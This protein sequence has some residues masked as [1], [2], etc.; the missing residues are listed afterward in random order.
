MIGG[1]LAEAS[2]ADQIKGC[3]VFTV[4]AL[5]TKP[6]GK[7]VSDL[8]GLKIFRKIADQLRADG[9]DITKPGPGSAC[10]GAVEIRFPNFEV[11]AII[12]VDLSEAGMANCEV[13]TWCVRPFWRHPSP[14]EVSRGWISVCSAIDK[15]LSEDPKVTSLYRLTENEAK[16]HWEKTSPRASVE[17]D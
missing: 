2:Q 1:R 10:A 9:F 17:H 3:F 4:R 5:E 13:L 8:L 16:V 6:D 12:L 7:R 14:Q 15:V 11:A